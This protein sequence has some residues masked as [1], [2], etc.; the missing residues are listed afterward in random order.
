MCTA[1]EINENVQE[2][3]K[4]RRMQ[5]ELAAEITAIEDRLK[6]HMT[7]CGVY[8]LDALTGKVTWLENTSNRFDSAAMKKELPALYARYCKPIS[9]RYFRL[10]K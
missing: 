4:L 1:T 10:Q 6:A 5:E 3:Q 2:L 9:V 7:E 8:E